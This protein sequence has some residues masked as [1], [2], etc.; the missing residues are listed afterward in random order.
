MQEEKYEKL[1]TKF[2]EITR[3]GWIKGVTEDE[4][5]V[6][7]TFENELGKEFDSMYFPDYYGTE[8]KC[9]TRYSGYPISLFSLSFDGKYLYQ[10]NLLLQ[11]YGISNP[12][13]PNKKRLIGRLI[14]FKKIKINDFYL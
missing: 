8:I 11:K 5:S 10:M 9:T 3:R 14:S 12:E 1:I 7:L 6:G 13:Y 4:S 2:E